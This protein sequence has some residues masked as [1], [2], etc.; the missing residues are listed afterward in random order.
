MLLSVRMLNGVGNVN[1]F[2]YVSAVEFTEG[3]GPL[4]YFQLIDSSLDKGM[5]P[6]GRRYAPAA[7]ATLQ[8]VVHSIDDA[9]KVTRFASQPFANDPSIWALQLQSTDVIR[10]TCSMQLV[11]TEGAVVR[12]GSASAVI[13]AY[14]QTQAK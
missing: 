10:G 12:R 13:N 7:G 9:K 1:T 6:A 2:E 8:C 3:D 4:I 11:L 14:A 5:R